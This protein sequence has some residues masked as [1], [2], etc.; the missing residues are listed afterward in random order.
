[1][2]W[3]LCRVV[4]GSVRRC[5][6]IASTGFYDASPTW[7]SEAAFALLLINLRDALGI[8]DRLGRRIDFTDDLPIGRDITDAVAD[9]RNAICHNGSPLR[10]FD[11]DNRNSLSFGRMVGAGTLLKTDELELSNP[12]PD[13][14]AFFYGKQRLLLKRHIYRAIEELRATRKSIAAEFGYHLHE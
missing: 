2:T 14:V 8:A 7:I 5:I 10:M 3:Q 6:E 12:Y 1:M 9:M 4:D 11:P 13:D